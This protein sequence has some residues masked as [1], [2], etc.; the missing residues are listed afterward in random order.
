VHGEIEGQMLISKEYIGLTD[1]LFA[2]VEIYLM[3]M[4]ML[5]C[6]EKKTLFVG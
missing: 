4:L 3:L 2:Y 1:T 6:Y 5:I